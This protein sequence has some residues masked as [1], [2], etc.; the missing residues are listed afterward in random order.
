MAREAWI[1]RDLDRRVDFR[2]YLLKCQSNSK[3]QTQSELYGIPVIKCNENEDEEDVLD[4]E[5]VKDST[6]EGICDQIEMVRSMLR[7]MGDGEINASAYDVAWVALVEDVSTSGQ[8]QFPSALEWISNN[9]LLDG[10]WG[11]SILF[12]A[13]DRIIF[14]LACVTALKTWNV[15]P[16]KVQRGLKFIGQNMGK[17]ED[18]KAEHMTIGFEIAFPNLL[19]LAK[20]VD[21]KIPDSPFLKEIYAQRNL[22]LT[23]IPKDL[24][25]IIPTTLLYSLEGMSG[26]DWEKLLELQCE[27]GSFLFSPSSTAYALMQTKDDKCLNYLKKVVQRFQGGVPNVYPVDLFEHIYAVDRLQRLG[28]SRYFQA[29]IN[30]CLHYVHRYW[31]EKGICWARA[32]NTPV[33][34]IDDTAMGFR[35]L[36]LHG[37]EVSPDVFRNFKKGDEFVCFAG[38][39]S[40]AVTGMFNLYRASQV[41]FPGEKIFDEAKNYAYKYLRQKQACGELFDKWIITKDLPGEVGYALDI[42]WYASL[43]RLESRIYIQQYGGENDVWIGKT[44]YRMPFVNN[45]TYLELAKSDYNEC[46][47]FHQQEWDSLQQWYSQ[48]GIFEKLGIGRR[49][50]LVSY[51]LAAASVYEPGRSTERLA[52]AKSAV[53][54]ESVVSYLHSD[55]TSAAEQKKMSFLNEFR[56]KSLMKSAQA[57]KGNSLKAKNVEQELAFILLKFLHQLSL[58]SHLVSETDKLSHF[59]QAWEKWMMTVDDAE[60]HRFG[61][62]AELLVQTIYMC[63]NGQDKTFPIVTSHPTY[64]QLSSLANK[65]CGQLRNIQNNQV[66]EIGSGELDNGRI[67]RVKQD[68]DSEMQE[69]VQ[70]VLQKSDTQDELDAN[71]KQTMFTVV[72]SFY[73]IAW[74]NPVTISDHIAKVLFERVK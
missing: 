46:Q 50:L 10:S 28:I 5:T 44:L 21:I 56:S 51:Y 40:G 66:W 74:C 18:E 65:I 16:E 49:D 57:Y 70:L 2:G 26:L 35:L 12:S 54:I 64:S 20:G 38:Q 17:L 13:H 22:K 39:S 43:P 37:F 25:H 61:Q 47:A 4:E 33:E 55:G 63:A 29:E 9:Q 11:D 31:T 7:S 42:P 34:D 3:P 52:W 27:D 41:Q 30:E 14:T 73:Y 19:E 32:R 15:H 48:C 53:L 23:R 69:F 6:T 72:R 58:D 60:G 67:S 8:P 59:C 45:D 1:C 36:R 62:E 71:I 68:T 24:M